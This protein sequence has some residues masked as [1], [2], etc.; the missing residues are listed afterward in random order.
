MNGRWMD[1][2]WMDRRMEDGWVKNKKMM[3]DG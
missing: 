2:G 1:E 3:V